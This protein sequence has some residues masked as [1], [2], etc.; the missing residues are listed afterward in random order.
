MVTQQMS[1]RA[2]RALKE[3]QA[4]LGEENVSGNL[5]VRSAYRGINY[6]VLSPWRNPPESLEH[7]S[8]L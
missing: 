6:N 2:T 5:A 3:L 1:E 7:S 4:S 8:Q